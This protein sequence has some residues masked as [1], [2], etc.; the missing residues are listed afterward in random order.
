LT[1]N[2]WRR[3]G[4]SIGS[5]DYRWSIIRSKVNNRFLFFLFNITFISL[6]Q[7]LLLFFI[8]TP[9]YVFLLLSTVPDAEQTGIPYLAFSRALLFFVILETVADQQ[10]WT[11]QKA[12]RLYEKTARIPAEYRSSFTFE[13]LDRGF[14]VKGL[15]SL[16]RHPNCV[17]EQ[18]FW[19]TLYVWACYSTETYVNWTGIGALGYIL[20]FQGS[21]VFTESITAN[22][23][24]EYRD[25]QARVG[26]FVPRFSL[27]PRSA[28]PSKKSK[29]QPNA[30]SKKKE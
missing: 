6:T 4:Y 1:F 20:L 27:N 8:T 3:G 9:T 7:S 30:P 25:Y 24:C 18:S 13:D 16:C 14:V 29:N 22:K 10:Q 12:K 19:V 28:V 17:A 2:Y 15:W 21:T 5:E 26:M 23:Y 11:F